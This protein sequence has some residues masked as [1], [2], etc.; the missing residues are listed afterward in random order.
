MS[1]RYKFILSI[2]LCIN[3]YGCSSDDKSRLPDAFSSNIKSRTNKELSTPFTTKAKKPQQ[4][5][6][7]KSP[8]SKKVTKSHRA[9]RPQG[10]FYKAFKHKA[11]LN[12]FPMHFSE[13]AKKKKEPPFKIISQPIKKQGVRANLDDHFA[14]NKTKHRA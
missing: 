6:A 14:S 7:L 11:N 10:S 8:F 1:A 4:K 2:S 5:Q 3:L 9:K 12:A 13:Q